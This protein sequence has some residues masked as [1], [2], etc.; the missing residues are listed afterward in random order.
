VFD[1]APS[2]MAVLR[3]PEHVF[4]L[5]NGP[6]LQAAGNR[7][8]IGKP[9][10][11]AFPELEG[12]G[13]FELL[14]GVYATGLPVRL[15]E[16]QVLLDRPGD[17]AAE[18][19]FFTFSYQPLH[20]TDGRIDGILVHGVDVTAQV[21]AHRDQEAAATRL[22]EQAEAGRR[23]AQEATATQ[24]Q[25][26]T[27]LSALVT[28]RDQARSAAEAAAAAVRDAN[29]HLILA[30]LR[31]QELAEAAEAARRRAAFLAEA[32]RR[33]GGAFAL[34]SA[35][36]DIAQLAVPAVADCCLFDIVAADGALQR[37]GWAHADPAQQALFDA[38][39][40]HVPLPDLLGHPVAAALASGEPVVVPEVTDA[41][42]QAAAISPEHVQFLRDLRLRSL[43]TVPLVGGGRPLGAMT[44]GFTVRS[45]R[46]YTPDTL[47][48][49]EDLAARAAL[50]LDNARLNR[51][52]RQAVQIR[53]DFLAST[54]HDLRTPLTSIGGYAQL[55]RR[56]LARAEAA[57]PAAPTGS[58][59]P[60]GPTPEGLAAGLASIE[61]TVSKMTRLVGALLDVARLQ[62]GQAMQLDRNP[63]DL[64]AAARR[65]VAEHQ[66]TTDRHQIRVE[67]TE[68]TLVG[69]WD[70]ARLERVLD[71]L[72]GNA[73]RYSPDGGAVVVSVARGGDAGDEAILTVRDEGLG[74]PAADLPRLFERF[75]RGANVAGRIGGAGI[76]LADV[77]QIV[78]EHGGT[79]S[80][81]SR[82][83]VGVG[84]DRVGGG[85]T[86]T[87][88]LPLAAVSA[89]GS[90]DPR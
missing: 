21:R 5:A 34:D 4:A 27:E 83:Q 63:T 13:Y 44:F 58:A 76:G 68:P 19:T 42:L 74:I 80:V 46:R 1:Y 89:D 84:A 49:A 50:A 32:S 79:V 72:I 22:L 36:R 29:Q 57:G 59:R 47:A 64:V 30:G 17:G 77:H 26:N 56:Q 82:E 78:A 23:D 60:L 69:Q 9:V 20:D 65:A 66:A 38:V 88:R 14:D 2:L 35:L 25:R 8:L 70:A 85:S 75:H 16:A 55:L 86:F 87:V 43:V 73:V 90:G 31:E 7:P 24:A 3:G 81:E 37:V 11:A 61:A 6:Y 53:D 39:G 28:G 15:A 67:A 12:Q 33:L 18:E 48:L 41:W 62:A 52:L 71:N 10:R 54:A 40:D 51:E 45:G